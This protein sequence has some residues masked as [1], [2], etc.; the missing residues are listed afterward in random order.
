[1]DNNPYKSPSTTDL[2]TS[3]SDALKFSYGLALLLLNI[4]ATIHM[5]YCG[6]TLVACGMIWLAV[7]YFVYV[8]F[9]LILCCVFVTRDP[10]M[11]RN[12]WQR[13]FTA[14]ELGP[15]PASTRQPNSPASR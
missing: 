13:Q 8:V 10:C 6:I 9:D 1:M 3:L 5:F 12:L 14:D 2:D 7:F 11:R 15:V 4:G